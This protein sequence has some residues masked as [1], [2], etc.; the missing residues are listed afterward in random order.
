LDGYSEAVEKPLP[1]VI[2]SRTI[3]E[4][5]AGYA[6]TAPGP[7]ELP[8]YATSTSVP[9]ATGVDGDASRIICSRLPGR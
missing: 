1:R 2:S 7:Q 3:N 4:F 6:A 9:G 5:K 8:D